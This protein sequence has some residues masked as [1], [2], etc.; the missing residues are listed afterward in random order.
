MTEESQPESDPLYLAVVEQHATGV[1]S[2]ARET[3][4]RG[5]SIDE[6]GVLRL[7]LARLLTSEHE[8]NRLAAKAADLANAVARQVTIQR[9]GAGRPL[10]GLPAAMEH[11]MK[12]IAA[13]RDGVS[14]AE[15][16][17]TTPEGALP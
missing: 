9:Q 13:D 11:V 7:V 2:Q 10:D 14:R 5:G 16:A 8:V 17:E 1:F 15:H 3:I 4:A 6:P 12:E